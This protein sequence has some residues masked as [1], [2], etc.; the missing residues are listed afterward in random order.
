MSQINQEIAASPTTTVNFSTPLVRTLGR[1]PSGA[2]SMSNFYGRNL[3]FGVFTTSADQQLINVS[4]TMN[5]VNQGFQV[6]GQY[7]LPDFSIVYAFC[8][9]NIAGAQTSTYTFSVVTGGGTCV[10]KNNITSNGDT[11]IGYT[12]RATQTFVQG[13]RGILTKLNSSNAQVFSSAYT[14]T[15][16]SAGSIRP[17]YLVVGNNEMYVGASGNL[18]ASANGGAN[19][20]TAGT[21]ISKF[22]SNGDL[23]WIRAFYDAGR[24][25]NYGF[26]RFSFF[27]GALYLGNR[28]STAPTGSYVVTKINASTGN[29]DWAVTGNPNPQLAWT[30]VDVATDSTGVYLVGRQTNVTPNRVIVVKHNL[31]GT[32]LYAKNY[33][34][35]G[36]TLNHQPIRATAS[37]GYLLITIDGFAAVGLPTCLALNQDGSVAWARRLFNGTNPTTVPILFNGVL[38]FNNYYMVAAQA[39][40]FRMP[41]DGSLVG[42]YPNAFGR[43]SSDTLSYTDTGAVTVTDV[44]WQIAANTFALG[45]ITSAITRVNAGGA[46]VAN[47]VPAIRNAF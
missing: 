25:D 22:N 45:T 17:N 36:S 9:Y 15:S 1:V 44:P 16:P 30:L 47:A 34:T 32:F 23:V 4:I 6:N 7:T 40:S 14:V 27:D 26:S 12:L 41:I 42:T 8:N 19:I 28:T 24:F 11:Y 10:M 20:G 13:N 29:A 31:S 5:P 33:I 39:G 37:A 3:Y 46:P 21:H 43:T 18:N 35:T 38:G 2:I